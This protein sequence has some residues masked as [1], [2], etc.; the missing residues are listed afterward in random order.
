VEKHF[1]KMVDA[2][3][4]VTKAMQHEL[5]QNWGIKATVLYDQ[6]PEFFHPTTLEEKHKL[7]C[8]LEKNLTQPD[9]IQDCAII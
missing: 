3:P 1:G 9:G 5:A 6:P 8:R 7:F 4:C 2:S